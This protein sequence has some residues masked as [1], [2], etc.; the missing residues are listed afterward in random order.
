MI[1]LKRTHIKRKR[2][3]VIDQQ[4]GLSLPEYRSVAKIF[5]AFSLGATLV[6]CDE[7]YATQRGIH[8]GSEQSISSIQRFLVNNVLCQCG[9]FSWNFDRSL[10]VF[11]LCCL[12]LLLE[13]AP[14]LC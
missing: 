10:S 14:R 13:E 2:N 8:A 12:F 3:V 6:H 9:V 7:K 4:A 5:L 1:R 11:C